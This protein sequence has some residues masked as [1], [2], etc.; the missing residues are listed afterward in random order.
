MR[1]EIADALFTKTQQRLLGLLFGKP[2]ARFFTNEIVR[3][4][5]MGRGTIRR[6]LDRLSSAGIINMTREGNQIY[7]QAN[8]DTPVFAELRAIVRKTFGVVDVIR[9]ALQTLG[10]RV[11]LAFVYGSVAK[12]SDVKSSD[13]DLMV[14]GESLSYNDVVALLLPVEESLGRPVNPT[15]Y[16]QTELQSKLDQGN[17]F[18]NRVLERP[19]LWVKGKED[20]ITAIREPG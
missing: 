3:W 13:I 12:A 8:P 18:L 1:I 2:D 20:D 17:S 4:A 16:S 9:N 6:E 10:D 5:D 11:Q 15:I 14:V 7:Y 19:K